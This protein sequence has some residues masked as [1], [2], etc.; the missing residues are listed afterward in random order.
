MNNYQTVHIYQQ[1]LREKINKTAEQQEISLPTLA[2]YVV[3]IKRVYDDL[4]QAHYVCGC[5]KMSK[6]NGFN[7]HI[8]NFSFYDCEEK[9]KGKSF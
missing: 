8:I 7:F 5:W 6:E 1:T 2:H 3:A 9:K 4:S